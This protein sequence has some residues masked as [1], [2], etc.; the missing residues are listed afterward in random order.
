MHKCSCFSTSLLTLI[1]IVLMITILTG[2]RWHLLVGDFW[3]LCLVLV[4][5]C[6]IFAL[7]WWLLSSCSVQAP[8]HAASVVAALSCSEACGILV[9]WPGIEPASLALKGRFLTT[10]PPG[11]LLIVVLTCISPIINDVENLF[12]YLLAICMSSLG[13]CLFKSSANFLSR[14]FVSDVEL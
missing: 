8:E 12:T 11:K 9:P 1:C 3:G 14:L 7:A 10:G 13:N 6:G 5:S 4:A 2:E